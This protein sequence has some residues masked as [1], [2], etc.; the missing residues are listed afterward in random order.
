MRRSDPARG[1]MAWMLETWMLAMERD[2]SV[3]FSGVAF[4][5]HG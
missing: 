3:A 4:S 5:G 2:R 1:G